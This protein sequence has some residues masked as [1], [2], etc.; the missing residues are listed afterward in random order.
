MYIRDEKQLGA[1]LRRKR[2]HRDLTQ[3]QLAGKAGLRQATI[4][5]VEDGKPR[6]E[7]RT[8]FDIMAALGLEL[9]LSEREANRPSKIEDI[10]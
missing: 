10:F 5:S 6:T 3:T 2:R 9:S 4:S 7:I 8:V 1:A